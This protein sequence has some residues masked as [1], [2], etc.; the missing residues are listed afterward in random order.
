MRRSLNWREDGNQRGEVRGSLKGE[1][2]RRFREK[3][4]RIKEKPSRNQ[5]TI[6]QPSN[7]STH[8]DVLDVPLEMW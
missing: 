5:A 2:R 6:H 4:T 3:S 1:S 7:Q 8:V